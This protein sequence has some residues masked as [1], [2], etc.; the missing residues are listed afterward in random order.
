MGKRVNPRQQHY[1]YKALLLGLFFSAAF[2]IPYMVLGEGY[3][4]YYGDFNVQQV[5]F[6][7]LVHDAIRSGN[8]QWSTTTDLGSSLIGS[9]TSVAIHVTKIM[10]L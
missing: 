9:F 1:W 2:F 6:Y 3:F 4:L 10:P 7:K 5:P 8:W